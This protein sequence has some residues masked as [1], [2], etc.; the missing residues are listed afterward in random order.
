LTQIK[1]FA[2]RGAAVAVAMVVA[3]SMVVSTAYAVV[4]VETLASGTLNISA[5]AATGTNAPT[6]L[7]TMVLD[8]PA[9]TD[10]PNSG[11]LVITAP[12]GVRLGGTVTA[13]VVPN[14][15]TNLDNVRGGTNATVTTASDGSTVTVTIASG[16]AAT[17]AGDDFI[18]IG[19][20]AVAANAITATGNLTAGTGS[21]AVLIPA[22]NNLGTLTV[23]VNADSNEAVFSNGTRALSTAAGSLINLYHVHGTSNP[24][25]GSW[26]IVSGGG[27]FPQTGSTT[28]LFVTEGSTPDLGGTLG[29][30]TAA[31]VSNIAYQAPSATGTVSLRF[32]PTD[33][34]AQN[35][36]LTLTQPALAPASGSVASVGNA[37]SIGTS[38]NTLVLTASFLGSNGVAAANGTAVNVTTNLGTLSGQTNGSCPNTQACSGTLATVS[39][40]TG[41]YAVTLTH[42]GSAGTATVNFTSG[43][44]TASI[45]IV[46]AGAADTIVASHGAAAAIKVDINRTLA[47]TTTFN[48]V[49]RDS[50]GTLIAN[51]P[52][53]TAAAGNHAGC[54]NTGTVTPAATPTTNS[55]TVA[56]ASTVN[57]APAGT[58]CTYTL[59]AA[60]GKTTTVSYTLRNAAGAT[61]VITI[62]PPATCA[63]NTVCTIT[64]TVHDA[65]G[66][67]VGDDTTVTLAVSTGALVTTGA[68]QVVGGAWTATYLAP[69][70]AQNVTVAASSSATAVPTVSVVFGVGG[71]TA[72]TPGV[73]TFQGTVEPS[74]PSIIFTSGDGTLADLVAAA[75]AQ[76]AVSLFVIIDSKYVPYV[77]GAP[78]AVNKAFSDHFAGGVPTA[79]GLILFK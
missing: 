25:S 3:M 78:A 2:W 50:A 57:A 71:A 76:G 42:Q 52:T 20:T 60:T 64:G 29:A 28:S 65:D 36:T 4:T 56:F 11:V 66:N 16:G 19:L 30:A 9:T 41:R 22:V 10:C 7:P 8:C 49:T 47:Q 1:N 43:G 79:T 53:V 77:V 73:I 35:L 59:T 62:T 58:V 13:G 69:G 5:N 54:A 6:A 33:G 23:S 17:T 32:T 24:Q 14:G 75:T 34:T 21:T 48:Y 18:V 39:S 31:Q 45:N 15:Q 72:P 55:G 27:S 37:T 61:S 74:G 51:T 70:T 38:G 68:R 63:L 44:V 67:P 46:L 12:T 26:E 40:V